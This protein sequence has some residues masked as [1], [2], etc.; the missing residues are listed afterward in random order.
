MKQVCSLGEFKIDN[1]KLLL[2]SLNFDTRNSLL[3]KLYEESGLSIE[4]LSKDI[5]D[6]MND[7][8]SSMIMKQSLFIDAMFL[9]E[10]LSCQEDY[11]DIKE[12]LEIL[13]TIL[14]HKL[15]LFGIMKKN[16]VGLDLT[17]HNT[18]EVLLK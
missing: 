12:E 2:I 11:E 14:S 13:M 16:I 3:L 10:M 4:S 7:H 18:A 1:L 6:C 17:I 15:R 5:L 8:D 9:A